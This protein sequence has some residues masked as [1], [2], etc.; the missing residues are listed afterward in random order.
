M[1]DI[2]IKII[3]PFPTNR[4][5]Q[6]AYD[7]LRIDPEPK[8]NHIK[9]EYVLD[10]NILSVEFCGDIAKNVRTALT[11][12]YESLILCVETQDQFGPPL[13]EEYNYY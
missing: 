13:S 7:V 3:I 8:R 9:K 10:D 6:I 2:K 4:A 11:N 5:A 1:E 12:F